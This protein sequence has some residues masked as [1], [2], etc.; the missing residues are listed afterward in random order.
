MH[1]LFEALA[2]KPTGHKREDRVQE[3]H[4]GRAVLPGS[5]GSGYRDG[6]CPG[7]TFGMGMSYFRRQPGLYGS[8]LH[9]FSKETAKR[10]DP[11]GASISVRAAGKELARSPTPIVA[12]RDAMEKIFGSAAIA[13]VRIA[14]KTPAKGSRQCRLVDAA[15]VSKHFHDG[16]R[17]MRVIRPAPRPSG[18][19]PILDA[20][21]SA[22][23]E[24]LLTE[25]IAYGQPL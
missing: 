23:R 2:C 25:G 18:Q 22:G 20:P 15:V 9:I 17:H 12:A 8:L 10:G 16:Q 21:S 7:L 14:L 4:A 3:I 24:E 6:D 13:A 11:H 1:G 19:L 5:Q